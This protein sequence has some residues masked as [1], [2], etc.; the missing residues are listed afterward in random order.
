LTGFLKLLRPGKFIQPLQC[1]EHRPIVLPEQPLRN[2][3]AGTPRRCR[4]DGRQ[5]P[6]DGFFES[7]M[8]LSTGNEGWKYGLITAGRDAEKVDNW[9]PVLEGFTNA[10]VGRQS[11]AA[12]C[13]SS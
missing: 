6:R 7:G 11:F 8:P 2:M 5:T 10:S 13:G 3:L 1:F 9:Y 12:A 4:S